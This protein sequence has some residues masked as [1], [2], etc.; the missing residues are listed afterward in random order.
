[1]WF[2]LK[3]DSEVLVEKIKGQLKWNKWTKMIK[4]INDFL[5]SIPALW[6]IYKWWKWVWK[7]AIDSM[8]TPYNIVKN[9]KKTDWFEETIKSVIFA[10]KDIG[11]VKWITKVAWTVAIPTIW[12]IIYEANTNPEGD[13]KLSWWNIAA[14][15]A[16]LM[17]LGVIN[18]LIIETLNIDE[19]I[20]NEKP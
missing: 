4:S 18:T 20:L 8:L 19:T 13:M 15:Y 7:Q 3:K 14:N 6:K 11:V 9:I 1:M 10:D 12:E 17:Y 2:N 5:E 16:E